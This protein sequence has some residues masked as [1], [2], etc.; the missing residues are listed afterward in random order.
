MGQGFERGERQQ[1]FR[2]RVATKVA[3]LG[4]SI[5]VNLSTRHTEPG[6]E[7]HILTDEAKPGSAIDEVVFRSPP[8]VEMVLAVAFEPVQELGVV[9]LGDLWRRYFSHLKNVEEKPRIE[10]PVEQVDGAGV[11]SFSFQIAQTVPIPRLWFQDPAGGHLV[12][13]QNNWF[14][15][16]WRK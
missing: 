14:A 9:A 10:M 8:L 4:A 13:I 3:W 7:R 15:R 16:N 11:P 2:Q 12:Q 1:Q 6:K 5:E